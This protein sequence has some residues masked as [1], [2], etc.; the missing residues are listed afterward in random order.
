MQ[1]VFIAG[2]LGGGGERVLKALR[3]GLGNRVEIMVADTL[4]PVPGLVG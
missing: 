4:A 3:T 2:V 1:A